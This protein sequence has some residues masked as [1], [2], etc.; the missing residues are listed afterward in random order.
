MNDPV[1]AFFL[2]TMAFGFGAVVGMMAARAEDTYQPAPGFHEPARHV[3]TVVIGT[4]SMCHRENVRVQAIQIHPLLDAEDLCDGCA[5]T[6][7]EA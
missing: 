4:C 1:T 2:L 5:R 6:E 7:V 3:A